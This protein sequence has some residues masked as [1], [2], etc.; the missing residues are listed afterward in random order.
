MIATTCS[1]PAPALNWI[2]IGSVSVLPSAFHSSNERLGL[3]GVVGAVLAQVRPRSP[4]CPSGVMPV[5]V[6]RLPL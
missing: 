2:G 1:W 5:D 6:V 3:L 4:G